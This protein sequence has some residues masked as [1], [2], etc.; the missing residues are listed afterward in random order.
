MYLYWSCP[1]NTTCSPSRCSSV[2]V[3]SCG[4]NANS[5]SPA[6]TAPK[7]GDENVIGDG[8]VATRS[9]YRG[10]GRSTLLCRPC[11][12]HRK[13]LKS[14]TLTHWP[15]KAP[16][17]NSPILIASNGVLLNAV[18]PGHKMHRGYLNT[19]RQTS[20]AHTD[21]GSPP[22]FIISLLRLPE[23]CIVVVTVCCANFVFSSATVSA[24]SAP[25]N[26]PK[27]TT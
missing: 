12:H 24:R 1:S 25:S 10:A 8:K 2:M 26:A 7:V 15:E 13:Y 6:A 9:V 22:L 20:P 3:D 11:L 14:R 17:H 4:Y 18:G 19:H 5:T 21:T 27:L 23:H 16:A